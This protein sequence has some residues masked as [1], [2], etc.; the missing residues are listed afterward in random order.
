VE[1]QSTRLI[2]HSRTQDKGWLRRQDAIS[3]VP[4]GAAL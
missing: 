3:E 4:V 2:F 1:N